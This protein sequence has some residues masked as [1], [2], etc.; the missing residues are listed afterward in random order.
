MGTAVW[1]RAAGAQ[2]HLDPAMPMSPVET[3]YRIEVF[4]QPR[5]PWRTSPAEAMVDAVRL[6]LASWD[7]ARQE[8]YLAV[9]VDLRVLHPDRR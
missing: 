6:D 5:A 8:Y 1:K 3:K 9:P 4:G 2:A 7:E